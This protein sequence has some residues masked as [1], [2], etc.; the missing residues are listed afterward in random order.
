VS[1]EQQGFGISRT[2]IVSIVLAAALAGFY[3]QHLLLKDTRPVVE[4]SNSVARGLQQV[5]ARLWE[6]PLFA[7]QH[8]KEATGSSGKEQ[9]TMSCAAAA[10]PAGGS[11][12]TLLVIVPGGPYE[13]AAETRRRTRYAV[14]T[15]LHS[16]GYDPA[17]P[18]HLGCFA[19]SSPAEA[20]SGGR[21]ASV[22]P[23]EI[24]AG[25][26]AGGSAPPDI[27]VVWVDENRLNGD[28]GRHF[29]TLAAIQRDSRAAIGR[30]TDPKLEPEPDVQIIGPAS[31][32]VLSELAAPENVVPPGMRFH[33]FNYQ[34][35]IDPAKLPRD[36]EQVDCGQAPADQA[37][38]SGA[39]PVTICRVV[40]NDSALAQLLADE[41][42]TRMRGK[43]R[44]A[45]VY[46]SDTIYGRE[47]SRSVADKLDRL[48]GGSQ[49]TV[50]TTYLRGLDGSLPSLQ[51]ADAGAKAAPSPGDTGNAV[52]EL[53]LPR[54]TS[55]RPY[56]TAEGNSQLDYLEHLPG[57][58]HQIE[59]QFREECGP[60]TAIGLL[61]TDVYDKLLLL[62]ALRPR[63]P[64]A[65]F[66]TTDL[67]AR[68]FDPAEFPTTRGL[69]VASSFGLRPMLVNGQV[70]PSFRDGYQTAAFLATRL[71]AGPGA[72][73]SALDKPAKLYEIGRWGAFTLNE[74][75]RPR[76][77]NNL[78]RLGCLVL[79]IGG[80]L[81]LVLEFGLLRRLWLA[82]SL[83]LLFGLVMLLLDAMPL[84]PPNLARTILSQ[85]GHGE[86]LFFTAGVSLWPVIGL[87]V[88]G[89]LFCVYAA[90]EIFTKLGGSAKGIGDGFLDDS[91]KNRRNLPWRSTVRIFRRGIVAAAF[92]K[93]AGDGRINRSI[94]DSITTQYQNV[95]AIWTRLRPWD[96][97][98]RMFRSLVY[99]ALS[100]LAFAMLSIAF[101]IGNVPARGHLAY[102]CYMVTTVL[103]VAAMQYLVMLVCDA[104]SFSSYFIRRVRKVISGWPASTVDKYKQ[105]TNL[106]DPRLLADWID[107]QM[108]ADRTACI[109]QLIYFPFIA[110]S[111]FTV[112]LSPFLDDVP[113]STPVLALTAVGFGLLFYI[114]ISLR[115]EAERIR[116]ETVERFESAIRVESLTGDPRNL[117]VCLAGVMAFRKGAFM[118][119]SQQ[120]LVR[121]LLLPLSSLGGSALLQQLL[122]P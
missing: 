81:F 60:F 111:I 84:V 69:I 5:D 118:R 109:I 12:R 104:T 44:V 59:Q 21:L 15:A 103:N 24:F 34:A 79:V 74:D 119:L 18:E 11:T 52:P 50:S 8:F 33:I 67:D 26:S 93:P 6:D 49:C 95:K 36:F 20:I 9:D 54:L 3:G 76:T 100:M 113:L 37:S 92:R 87:R 65:V 114:A 86:P 13:Q 32:M 115:K 85:A 64:D 30:Q 66:F 35:T 61:G 41:I 98:P 102:W 105:E 17:D 42:P 70:I 80:W 16:R 23:F 57:P 56:E 110:L 78:Q 122:S 58:L 82:V 46:E 83:L 27:S 73:A 1:D 40:K 116:S 112:S 55:S 71:A 22:I 39:A 91:A 53:S 68:L 51:K 120:P 117:I 38:K 88:L 108:I 62:R 89:F 7:V 90:Y 77:L 97:R 99:T 107:M 121:A 48:C 96:W 2:S 47:L 75:A 94:Y 43:A 10:K 14:I 63:F 31:S 72:D 29:E 19:S 25:K 101:G 28:T 106:Q 4:A 45:L